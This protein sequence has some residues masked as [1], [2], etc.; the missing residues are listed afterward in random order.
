MEIEELNRCWTLLEQGAEAWNLWRAENPEVRPNLS[1]IRIDE[2]CDIEF[3]GLNLSGSILCATH[4]KKTDL[5]NSDLR[6]A[7][8]RR[9]NFDDCD[10]RHANLSEADCA[11]ATLSRS[12]LTHSNLSKARMERA[13]LRNAQVDFADLSGANLG[14][15]NVVDSNF[16]LSNLSGAD[17]TEAIMVKANLMDANLTGATLDRARLEYANLRGA[18]L[19]GAKLAHANLDSAMLYAATLT[20]ADFSGANLSA[21]IVVG[22]DVEKA[23]FDSCNIFGAAFWNLIGTPARQS[24]LIISTDSSTLQRV[25]GLEIAQFVHLLSTNR[26]IRDVINAVTSKLILVL[27]RFIPERKVVLETIRQVLEAEG[28][29]PVV[30]DFDRPDDRDLTETII[31]LAGMSLFVIADITNPR[32][33]PLELHAAVPTFN[34]PFVPIIQEGERPFD[35]F[36]DLQSSFGQQSEGRMLELL[37]YPSADVLRDVIK[38]AILIPA[39]ER[40]RLLAEQKDKPLRMRRAQDYIEPN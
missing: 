4:F 31:T 5:R 18:K 34:I 40:G 11:E 27:G 10:L 19:S 14:H 37:T 3:S 16:F 28:Y 35:M 39:L 29:V 8:L 25:N 21:A 7:D 17:L 30:F 12:L 38:Q 24:D 26:K 13:S 20:E 33:A 1:G 23:V 9:A 36:K 15:A 2:L 32:C 22:A 6:R